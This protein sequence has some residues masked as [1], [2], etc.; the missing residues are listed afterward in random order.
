LERLHGV[1]RVVIQVFSDER[2][3]APSAKIFVR[4]SLI[5]YVEDLTWV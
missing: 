1:E 5:S 3:S 4:S 2:D